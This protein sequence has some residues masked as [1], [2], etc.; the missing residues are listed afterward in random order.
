MTNNL[1]K[2]VEKRSRAVWCQQAKQAKQQSHV[3]QG[4]GKMSCVRWGFKMHE[5]HDVE[6][7][8][9]ENQSVNGWVCLW[10]C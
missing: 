3:Y 4:A 9:K 8:F 7:N 10:P 1:L 5:L 6:P 2:K